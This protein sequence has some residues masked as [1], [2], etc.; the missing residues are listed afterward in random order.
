MQIKLESWVEHSSNRTAATIS[1][2]KS[3]LTRDA[4]PHTKSDVLQHVD[5]LIALELLFRCSSISC[6]DHCDGL[7]RKKH[8]VCWDFVIS[9]SEKF[10]NV[11][12]F[13]EL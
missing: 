9:F 11:K 13:I 3:A 2:I 4:P 8:P 7:T 6:T 12:V 1:G 10:P 5:F